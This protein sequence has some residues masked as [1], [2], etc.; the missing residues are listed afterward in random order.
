MVRIL[1]YIL[2]FISILLACQERTGIEMLIDDPQ[3]VV[4]ITNVVNMRDTRKN[5]DLISLKGEFKSIEYVRFDDR[6]VIGKIVDI[7]FT[8]DFIFVILSHGGGVMKYDR[9][10]NFVRHIAW[11]GEGPKQV[12]TPHHLFVDELRERIYVMQHNKK[13]S[14][15]VYSFDGIFLGYMEYPFDKASF[16]YHLGDEVFFAFHGSG[17]LSDSLNY[18]SG[19]FD[20]SGRT[21]F[22]RKSYIKQYN[23]FF[24]SYKNLIFYRGDKNALFLIPGTHILYRTLRDTIIPAYYLDL[25]NPVRGDIFQL[26]YNPNYYTNFS[27]EHVDDYIWFRREAFFETD[28]CLYIKDDGHI[29]QYNRKDKNTNCFSLSKGMFGIPNDIDNGAPIWP[30]YYYPKENIYVQTLSGGMIQYLKDLGLLDEN[31]PAI[32]QEM[33]EDS[34]PLIVIYNTIKFH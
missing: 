33:N 5:E 15:S 28:S 27:K 10:G 22:A 16:V 8:K 23:P 3:E 21:Y 32:Y 25:K 26:S 30:T 17:L 13:S 4:S 14:V 34:N 24:S 18:G 7:A 1:I 12:Y 19:I 11:E 9:Q 6:K 29:W 31:A 20:N 2:I